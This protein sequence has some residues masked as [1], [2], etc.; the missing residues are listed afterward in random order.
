MSNQPVQ[1]GNPIL[2]QV[3]QC[4]QCVDKPEIQALI[5]KMLDVLQQSNGVGIASPQLGVSRRILVVAS[6]PNPRYPYAPMM[7][8]TPM[9]NPELISYQG[10]PEKDWE[11]CLSVPDQRGLVPRYPTIEVSYCDRQGQPQR[12]TL[13]GF[14]ARIFQ[15]ELDHL[16]GK[17]FLDR[18]EGPEDLFTEAEFLTKI[19]GRGVATASA[20]PYR[21]TS[22]AAGRGRPN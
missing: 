12:Q 15:H 17:V 6:H 5:D 16:N 11:G 22:P 10:T 7:A 4:V 1:L 3:A 8:P 20:R 18:V 21:L 13:V 9:I 2:R 14:V 19:A